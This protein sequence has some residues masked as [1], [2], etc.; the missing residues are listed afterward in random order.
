[1]QDVL[2]VLVLMDFNDAQMERFK[3][4]SSRLKFTRK[5]AKSL[6][7]I[8]SDIWAATDI[9]YT[10]SLLPE[11]DAVPR[12]RWVQSHSAGV[13]QLLS[14]SLFADNQNDI[15][16]TT[17]SG[18]HAITMAEYTF[19]MI[20]ALARKLP[21]MLRLQGHIEWPTDRHTLFLPRELR[22]STVG[23]IGYGSI[24]REIG[25]LAKAFG[26]EVLATKRDVLHPAAINEYTEP[27]TGDPEGACVD[28][29]YPPEATQSMAALC[30]FVIVLVPLTV[31][32][33]KVIDQGVLTAMKKTAFLINIAR[34]NVVDEEALI[35]ALQSGHIAGAGL[36]V[37]AQEPLPPTSPLWKMENVILSPHIAGANENYNQRAADIF[38]QN[39]ERYLAHK[40]L[41]NRVD[42]TRGY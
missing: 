42:R 24:G 19:A 35:K 7:D 11:P 5:V 36:D 37:F 39:L 3:Q 18:V 6:N 23:I 34:G 20:L 30:D 12:L 1:M 2:N 4:V 8:S 25:R 31:D 26:M 27:G 10:G 28:R 14:Q 41:L 16:L 13:E 33:Y 38:T 21:T 15:I 40:D 32:T 9:L 29:L 22:G 17:A